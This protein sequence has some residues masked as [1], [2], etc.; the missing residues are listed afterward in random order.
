MLVAILFLFSI[1]SVDSS[2]CSDVVFTA[3]DWPAP[4]LSVS[5]ELLSKPLTCYG[6]LHSATPNDVGPVL[7]VPGT[8]AEKAAVQFDLGWTVEL[9]KL[10]WPYRL[11]DPPDYGLGDIQI[12]DEYIVYGIRTMYQRANHHRLNIIGHFQGGMTPR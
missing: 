9:N 5:L 1:Q 4:P 7:F 12:S 10:N 6:D 11:I 3:I 8:G 2:N